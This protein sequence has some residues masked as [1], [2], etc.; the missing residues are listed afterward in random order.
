MKRRR[1]KRKRKKDCKVKK[2]HC[3]KAHS[4]HTNTIHQITTRTLLCLRLWDPGDILTHTFP[5][6]P[7]LCV[8]CALGR[9]RALID[10][11]RV[12]G[13]LM[14]WH[15]LPLYMLILLFMKLSTAWFV[16]ACCSRG[17]TF[18]RSMFVCGV[19]LMWWRWSPEG[20]WTV[21]H[22]SSSGLDLSSGYQLFFPQLRCHDP[23]I[24]TIT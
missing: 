6:T 13:G 19:F 14:N 24:M 22:L 4:T 21:G 11:L 1:E 23:L 15:F 9:W 8:D 2:G 16:T 20:R 17:G 18:V 12:P 10:H 3:L 7:S 5:H